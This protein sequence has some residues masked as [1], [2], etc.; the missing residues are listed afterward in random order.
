MKYLWIAGVAIL[1]LAPLGLS[2]Y[3]W[4][5]LA[6]TKPPFYLTWASGRLSTLAAVD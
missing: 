4:Y 2:N 6:V 1:A 5:I 3:G